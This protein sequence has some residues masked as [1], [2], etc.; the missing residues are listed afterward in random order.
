MC[1]GGGGGVNVYIIRILLYRTG[2][3]PRN[4]QG[5][6]GHVCGGGGVTKQKT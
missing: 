2:R 5:K 6:P 1:V 3:I 4:C